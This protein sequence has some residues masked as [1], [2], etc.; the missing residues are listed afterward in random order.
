MNSF[1]LRSHTIINVIFRVE[2]VYCFLMHTF[3]KGLQYNQVRYGIHR[4]VFSLVLHLDTMCVLFTI[5][6][7][8]IG[9]IH[10]LSGLTTW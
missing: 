5:Y 7:G 8:R 10:C 1:V 2:Y 6:V 9:R 4:G 3:W